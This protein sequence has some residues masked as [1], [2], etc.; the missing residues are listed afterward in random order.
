MTAKHNT[1]SAI[2]RCGAI[3]SLYEDT[4]VDQVV[5]AAVHGAKIPVHVPLLPVTRCRACNFVGIDG[6]ADGA[7]RW[8]LVVAGALDCD[9]VH[10]NALEHIRFVL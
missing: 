10:S 6:A 5:E 4:L 7:V 8:A 2:C 1:V 9:E 3:N